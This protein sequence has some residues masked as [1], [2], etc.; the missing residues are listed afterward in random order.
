MTTYH[1]QSMRAF[2]AMVVVALALAGCGGRSGIT[3]RVTDASTGEPSPRILVRAAP[4]DTNGVPLPVTLENLSDAK[5][6]TAQ[7]AVTDDSG[8]ASFSVR[9]KNPYLIELIAIDETTGEPGEA[10][11]F[12][13]DPARHS[14]DPAGD[15]MGYRVEVAR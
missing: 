5:H 4:L 9:P 1:R 14:C 13:V 15:D 2:L 3:L 6:A 11:R 7:S 8:T 12:I 10:A